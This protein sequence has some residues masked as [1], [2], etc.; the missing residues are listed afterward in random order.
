[1]SL[2]AIPSGFSSAAAMTLLKVMRSTQSANSSFIASQGSSTVDARSKTAMSGDTMFSIIAAAARSK[3]VEGSTSTVHASTADSG[4]AIGG[5]QALVDDPDF[6]KN[7]SVDQAAQNYYA[8]LNQVAE[9][10]RRTDG[11]TKPG[12]TNGQIIADVY[13][14]TGDSATAFATGFDSQSLK[15]VDASTL[16][17][18]AKVDRYWTKGSDGDVNG[19]GATVS[20]DRSALDEWQNANPRSAW[21]DDHGHQ[22]GGGLMLMW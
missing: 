13:K 7:Y 17:I 3:G 22:G 11:M 20:V 21:T 2:D 5:A 4:Q 8:Q 6:Q 9:S 16:N 19:S 1:M 18:A 15:I 10:L 14:L 12:Q